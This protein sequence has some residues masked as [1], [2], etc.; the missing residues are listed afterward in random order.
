MSFTSLVDNVD[1]GMPVLSLF[2]QTGMNKLTTKQLRQ[3]GR[4][5]LDAAGQISET[6]MHRGALIEKTTGS[7]CILG[8]VEAVTYKRVGRVHQDHVLLTSDQDDLDHRIY[9]AINACVVLSET[10][11]HL[12]ECDRSSGPMDTVTHYNDVHCPGGVVAYNMLRIAAARAMVL[13]DR[14]HEY[15]KRFLD[16][17][18]A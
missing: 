18:A 1:K 12:C 9:R 3:A 16:M 5:L 8:A 10:V 2:G 17:P 15:I 11:A 7:L 13:A 6:G 4:D 14:K